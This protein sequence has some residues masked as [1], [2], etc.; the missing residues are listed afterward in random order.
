MSDTPW[1]KRWQQLDDDELLY[2]PLSDLPVPDLPQVPETPPEARVLW[3]WYIRHP[4]Q[5][6]LAPGARRDPY[7]GLVSEDTRS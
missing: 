2:A 7:A 1:V 5:V 4:E 6:P 3:P